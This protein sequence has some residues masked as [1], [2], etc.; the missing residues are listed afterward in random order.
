MVGTELIDHIIIRKDKYF[1]F[2]AEGMLKGG[3]KCQ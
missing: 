1:G 3:N 2:Q